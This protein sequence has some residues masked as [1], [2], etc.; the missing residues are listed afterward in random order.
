MDYF[1]YGSE[2]IYFSIRYLPP[3][4]RKMNIHVH[5][6]GRVVADVPEGTSQQDTL[7]AMRQ[8]ARKIWQRVDA[9]RADAALVPQH[10][11]VNG[12]GHY[13]LGQLFPLDVRLDPG[14][15][16]GV[17]LV[18]QR[19]QVAA[20]SAQADHIC[21]LLDGW[22][23][24][25]AR[26][27]FAER[28]AAL[29]GGVDWLSAPPPFRLRNMRNQWGSCSPSGELLLNPQLV[30]APVSCID[31]ILWHE[32]CHIKHHNHSPEYYRLLSSALPNWK[33]CKLEL[34]ALTPR[35]LAPSRPS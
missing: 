18:D 26:Q 4:K 1:E 24:Q 31:Y 11:Y 35:L 23:R 3:T 13:Y 17:G 16:Q 6:D 30:K 32:L 5:P 22:Y 34:D 20:K 9:C 2:R 28:L 29:S 21:K 7:A 33:Q 14:A 8:H 19:C 27:V 12:E 10:R 25:Q 15:A